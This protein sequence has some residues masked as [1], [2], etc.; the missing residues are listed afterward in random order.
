MGQ[1]P[2]PQKSTISSYE[3]ATAG[4]GLLLTTA[5]RG[6]LLTTAGRGLPDSF[7]FNAAF[8]VWIGR[9]RIF[10]GPL[11]GAGVRNSFADSPIVPAAHFQEQQA[12][13]AGATTGPFPYYNRCRSRI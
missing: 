4:T 7:A 3:V 2:P 5:G 11:K 8:D 6:L 13:A 1:N 12:L 10:R 9:K